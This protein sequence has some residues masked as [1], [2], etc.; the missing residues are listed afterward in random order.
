MYSRNRE[1][2]HVAGPT[3]TE[4]E[5]RTRP[6]VRRTQAER[7]SATRAALLGAA[8]ELFAERGYA[9]TGREE[10]AARAGVTRG[11]LYHHFASKAEAFEA[12]VDELD[13]ELLVRVI[14]AARRGT[15][16]LDQL[17]RAA[18]A[19]IDACTEPAIARILLTDAPT[20]LG[21]PALRARSAATCQAL[22]EGV[23]RDDGID[24]PGT[25][26]VTAALLLG[27]L[28]E[29]ALLVASAPDPRAART[30]IRNTVDALLVKL[31]TRAEGAERRPTKL[32]ERKRREPST[33]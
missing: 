24:V 5:L 17:R 16:P 19:Y 26:A 18:R 10:I 11:A 4:D 8:R 1:G 21:W 20:V 32:S 25:P 9:A 27:L 12:V 15:D 6:P 33:R 3:R 29:A 7:R 22:L 28:D 31:L 2:A 14:T 23:L 13:A 30:R